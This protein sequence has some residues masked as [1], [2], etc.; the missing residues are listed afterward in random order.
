MIITFCGHSR[1]AKDSV[2]EISEKVLQVLKSINTDEQILFY[3][4]DYG[5]FDYIAMK[6]CKKYKEINENCKLC[7]ITPYLN[8]TYLKNKSC[9]IYDETIYPE[10]ENVPLK[11]AILKRNEWMVASCD[12]LVAYVDFTWGGAIKTLEYA[13]RKGKSYINLG[14]CKL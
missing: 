13:H 8:D 14:S 4:G 6:C 2:D 5:Q 11:Y 7:F 9:D 10:I 1:L 12:L 3:L